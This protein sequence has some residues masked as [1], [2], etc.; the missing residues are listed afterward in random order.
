MLCKSVHHQNTATVARAI[1]E[2]LAA[3]VLEPEH[4]NHTLLDE[5][6][7]IG[8]GS[9][10]YFGRL[11]PA[12]F[13]W[14]DSLPTPTVSCRKPAFIFSTAGLSFLAPVWH[15][16]LKAALAQ[17]GFDVVGEFHCRGFDTWGPLWLVGGINRPHPDQ[18]DIERAATFAERL[19]DSCQPTRERVLTNAAG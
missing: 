6:D 10:V 13:A 2:P 18:R 5:H 4:A 19:L 9:G 16:A 11:H 15:A 17:K 7:L 14:L 1:A 12:L 3:Q 8:F